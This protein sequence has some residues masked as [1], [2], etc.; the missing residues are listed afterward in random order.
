M[1]KEQQTIYVTWDGKS[2]EEGTLRGHY[3]ETNIAIPKS[4]G[5]SGNG[6]DPKELLISSAV[7][8]YVATLK[9]MLDQ[10]RAPVE[11][12]SLETKWEKKGQKFHIVHYPH[13]VMSQEAS[14][15]DEEMVRRLLLLAEEHC[16]VGKLLKNVGFTFSVES[17][18]SNES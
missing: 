3:L 9:H 2:T 1:E 12:F 5:G 14:E 16:E 7:T 18:I 17:K 10:R 15:K 6:T 11:R 8:C 13:A 4:L